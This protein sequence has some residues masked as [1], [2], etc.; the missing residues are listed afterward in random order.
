MRTLYETIS[1]ALDAAGFPGC[2]ID[3]NAKEVRV[4]TDSPE[5]VVAI[6]NEEGFTAGQATTF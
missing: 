5:K 1:K 3:L 4:E 6:L 2:E